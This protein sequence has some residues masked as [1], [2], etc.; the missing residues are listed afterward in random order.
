M[1]LIPDKRWRFLVLIGLVGISFFFP[2]CK[3]AEKP[4]GEELAL[5]EGERIYL[6]EFN[7]RFKSK[8]D[9]MKD[10]SELPAAKVDALKKELLYDLIDEKVMLHRIKVM[11]I[12][13]SDEEL[14]KRVDE[15]RKDYA[16]GAFEK[17]FQER[18]AFQSW[19][20]ELRKRILLEKLIELEVNGKITVSDREAEAYYEQHPSERVVQETVRVSQIVVEDGKQA[21]EV[22]NRLKKGEDFAKLAKELSTGPEGAREETSD[23]SHAAFSPSISTESFFPLNQ[24]DS[25]GLW[26]RLTAFISSRWWRGSR[27]DR[28]VSLMRRTGSRQG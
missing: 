9:L 22:L 19:Q 18:G 23:F 4:S 25:A 6:E 12:R 21:E 8:L 1:H 26:K 24:P 3:P 15:I 2:C 11:G 5:V 14:R 10:N 7:G 27:K 20:G 28:R 17:L 13:V 16:E